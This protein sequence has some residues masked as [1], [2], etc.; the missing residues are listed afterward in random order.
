ME[1]DRYRYFRQEA[2]ELLDQFGVGVT[3]LEKG[4]GGGPTVQRLLRLAHTLKGAARVVKQPEIAERAHAIE[5]VL[6]PLRDNGA[7][8]A[9]ERLDAVLAHLGD[10]AD[11]VA[12]LSPEPAAGPV[13]LA[14]ADDTARSV[15]ANIG[16]IDG[17][18]GRVDAAQTGLVQLRNAVD[19]RDHAAVVAL[20][21]VDRDLRQVR[22][23]AEQLRLAPAHILFG[24]LERTA[25]DAARALG[26]KVSFA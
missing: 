5:E 24:P 21:R 26:K 14:P 4:E 22:T 23:A 10:I 7:A 18:L 25:H 16:E 12:A 20:D 2:R 1:P 9:R 19:A 3:A 8:P 13:A 6:A 15:R 11:R 17:L